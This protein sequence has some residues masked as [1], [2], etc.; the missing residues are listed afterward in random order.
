MAGLTDLL[1]QEFGLIVK[2]LA[3]SSASKIGESK[4]NNSK[5]G[6][7]KAELWHESVKAY[8]LY[9]MPADSN[10]TVSKSAK[11]EQLLGYFYLDLHSRKGKYSKNRHRAIQRGVKDSSGNWV[12]YPM[13]ALVL[14]LP[15]TAWRQTHIK[16]LFHEM[17]HVLHNLLAVQDFYQTSGISIAPDLVEMPAKLFEMLSF[18]PQMQSR[19]LGAV[20]VE[21]ANAQTN[22]QLG[23]RYNLRLFKAAQ[24]LYFYRESARWQSQSAHDAAHLTQLE[25][26]NQSLFKHFVGYDYPQAASNQF[27]FSHIATYGPRYYSYM[28]SERLALQL[29]ADAKNQRFSKNDILNSIFVTGGSESIDQMLSNLY[30]NST[31]LMEKLKG[32]VQ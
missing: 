22:A 12:Q 3:E 26:I 5:A 19:Y 17:G 13:S 4:S 7:S 28:L 1:A 2:P 15:K 27:S 31:T 10:S 6:N 14:N 29:L 20:L 30:G 16:S 9:Q 11:T 32:D 8:A 23:T 25:S 24:A 18:Q 21:Q